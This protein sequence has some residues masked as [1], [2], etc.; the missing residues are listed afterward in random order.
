MRINVAKL[1]KTLIDRDM[2]QADLARKAG[3]S[4]STINTICCGRGCRADT[5]QR[6]ADAIQVPVSSILARPER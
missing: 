5:A 3:L 4:Y 6:I 2:K 1:K